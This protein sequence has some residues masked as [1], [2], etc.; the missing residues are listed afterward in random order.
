MQ[1]KNFTSSPTETGGP[2]DGGWEAKVCAAHFVSDFRFKN[3]CFLFLLVEVR[4]GCFVFK[5]G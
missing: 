2:S 4:N 3:G 1:I 5:I